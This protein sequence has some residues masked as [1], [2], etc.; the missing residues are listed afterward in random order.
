VRVRVPPSVQDKR[1]HWRQW[2]F[3]VFKHTSAGYVFNTEI[4]VF[5][6]EC[7]MNT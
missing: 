1:D 7:T 4:L 2:S 6:S 5:L 3:F